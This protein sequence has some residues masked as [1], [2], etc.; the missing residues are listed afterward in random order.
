MAN[1]RKHVLTWFSLQKHGNFKAIIKLLPNTKFRRISEKS[2]QTEK[3]VIAWLLIVYDKI[4]LALQRCPV[5][6]RL[7]AFEYFL[8]GT[9]LLAIF[10]TSLSRILKYTD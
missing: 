6:R 5:F 2:S 9:L 7:M 4:L 1:K 8:V 3:R 10:F